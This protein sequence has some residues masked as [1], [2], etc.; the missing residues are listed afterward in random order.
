LNTAKPFA[1]SSDNNKSPILAVLRGAFADVA[2]VL[3]IGSG[4]GQH[5]VYFGA[6]LDSVTWY[7]SDLRARHPGIQ[8]WID[9]SGLTNVRPPLNLDVTGAGWPDRHF[10]AV[11][12]ANTAHIMGWSAVTAM[13][14]GAAQVLRSGGWFALYG[15]FNYGGAYTSE[16]NERFDRVLRAD[17]P[18]SGIRDFESVEALANAVGLSLA[19]DHAMP[20]NNR[21]LV[22]QKDAEHSR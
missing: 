3:E 12:S 4:T 18:E 11:Y 5:A 21:L 14:T 10:D 1:P 22:W 13:F 16:G 2:S 19:G 9:E 7:T 6:K 20:A 17:D 15:P 8:A